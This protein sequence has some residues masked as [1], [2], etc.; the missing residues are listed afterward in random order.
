MDSLSVKDVAH[1]EFEKLTGGRFKMMPVTRTVTVKDNG[2]EMKCKMTQF[3]VNSS[4]AVTGH[5]LQG[6]TKDNIIVVSWQKKINWTYVVL[7]RV[8]TLDGLYLFKRLRFQD[9]KMPESFK[10]CLSFMKRMRT[11]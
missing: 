2:K 10:E 8:R 4:D 1:V 11:I 9:I 7:S 5:K 3:L 6:M